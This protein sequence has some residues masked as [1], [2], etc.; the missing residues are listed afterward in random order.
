MVYG[1]K[2][3]SCDPLMN[4]VTATIQLETIHI[5]GAFTAKSALT[6]QPPPLVSLSVMRM[7]FDSPQIFLH[8]VG[9]QHI[10]NLSTVPLLEGLSHFWSLKGQ[11][12][13]QSHFLE[14]SVMANFTYEQQRMMSI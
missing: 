14:I 3:S 13:G 9:Y 1:L 11:K 12:E 6:F 10:T 4:T 2:A 5:I 7:N 8:C